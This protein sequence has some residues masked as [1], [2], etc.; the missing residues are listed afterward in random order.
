MKRIILFIIA[1]VI[2]IASHIFTSR[3]THTIAESEQ[4]RIQIWADATEALL[5]DDYSDL[6]FSIVEQNDNIPI[7]I[8]DDNDSIVTFRNISQ[9]KIT[10]NLVESFKKKHSPIVINISET[11]HQYIIYDDSFILKSL[12]IFPFIQLILIILFLSL[13]FWILSAEKR[14]LQ[15]KLWVG[16]SRETAHQLGTPISSLSA[17]LELLRTTSPSETI[18]DMEKD[19]MRLQ[20]IANRFS[21]VG[22][23]P[24]L[25]PSNISVIIDN[26]I[27]YMRRRTSNKVIYSI[28]DKTINSTVYISEPLI[29][30]VIENLCKNSVDAMNGSG[31]VSIVIGNE[32]GIIFVEFSDTGKG[33][34]RHNFKKVFHPGFTTKQRGWGLG[35]SLARRI[36]NDY[37]HGSIFVKSSS[38]TGTTFRIELP[39]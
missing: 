3:I 28:D 7:I 23:A 39:Q 6:A 5:N 20:T 25:E 21:K 16:L 34:D 9:N 22:S 38:S 37:H 1:I 18:D 29:Q 8:I 2:L 19:V 33:I 36:I 4:Q 35:L 12:R 15:D 10:P 14:N 27:D 13:L 17:W 31:S 11:E 26:A 32:P 30:W 24:K